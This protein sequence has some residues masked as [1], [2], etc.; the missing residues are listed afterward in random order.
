MK[1]VE[2]N[3]E[4]PMRVGVVGGGVG[5]LYE[6]VKCRKGTEGIWN[7]MIQ[8]AVP[9]IQVLDLSKVDPAG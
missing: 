7:P 9:E 8:V 4:V 2:Y 6:V 3:L 5:V 1:E